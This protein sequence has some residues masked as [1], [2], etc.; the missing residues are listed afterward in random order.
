[1]AWGHPPPPHLQASLQTWCRDHGS[2]QR[3]FES[4]GATSVSASRCGRYRL[5]KRKRSLREEEELGLVR[6]LATFGRTSALTRGRGSLLPPGSGLTRG[7]GGWPPTRPRH[8]RARCSRELGSRGVCPLFSRGPPSFSPRARTRPSRLLFMPPPRPFHLRSERRG[9]CARCSAC[10]PSRAPLNF[11]ALAKGKLRQVEESL[12]S[13][14]SRRVPS[15]APATGQSKHKARKSNLA[16]YFVSRCCRRSLLD[17]SVPAG[18]RCG[19]LHGPSSSG[20]R[21]SCWSTSGR[22]SGEEVQGPRGRPSG[23]GR[24]PGVRQE[25]LAGF[26]A[27]CASFLGDQFEAVLTPGNCATVK[28]VLE[29]PLALGRSACVPP[30]F[31]VLFLAQRGVAESPLS[32]CCIKL[33]RERALLVMA[34]VAVVTLGLRD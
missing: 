3:S 6:A 21:T 22:T 12:S 29:L 4:G 31:F 14:L 1:M 19:Q 10:L 13:L 11:S 23:P 34:V 8:P 32:R 18:L 5:S 9:C 15:A 26:F 24:C 2:L 27:A 16:F 28:R 20:G 33:R 30:L 17:L 7:S 25:S